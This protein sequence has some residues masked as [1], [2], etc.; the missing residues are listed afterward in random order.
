MTSNLDSN[1]RHFLRTVL[2]A[3]ATAGGAGAFLASPLGFDW[4]RREEQR[5]AQAAEALSDIAA[6]APRARFWIAANGRDVSCAACHETD[7]V[8][9][10]PRHIH[11][12]AYVGC[13][14]CAHRCVIGKGKRGRCRARMNVNGELRSLVYGHPISTHVDPV[15][16][17]P[18]YHFLPGAS[19]FSLATSGCP[20]HCRFCQNWTISQA[21]P[22]DYVEDYYGP[23]VIAGA[24]KRNRAP[25]I[26]YT[27]N[28]PTVFTEYL[29][30][31][32]EAGK[33]DGLRSV[34][35]SCGFMTEQPLAAMCDALDAIKIDLKGY[36]EEFYR[37]VCDAEM[38]PVLRSIKQVHRSGTHL[39]IVN[40][41]VPTLNDSEQMLT[42]L[43]KWVVGELGPD[44]PVH[45]TRF[46]PD[47]K[48]LNLP[49]TPVSTLERAREIA[50]REGMRYPFVGNVPGHEG[51][52]TYCPG[53]G[54]IVIRRQ[55]FFVVENHVEAGKC[56]F[57]GEVIAGVWE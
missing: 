55:S 17:K 30:D 52:H 10:E 46:H 1:R 14:L 45:Y 31:I 8:L 38:Q 51:N 26:A 39:E 20:L 11:T 23:E 54:E 7:E 35:I 37:N 33:R 9:P 16:K 32:A 44:V 42:E 43:A 22:E 47:Y 57:C 5:V 56:K 18:L 6:N 48:L 2:K 41:V 34:L 13:T 53:C 3:G 49:P 36:S 40:L 12:E 29:L 27:Y 15:E 25:I 24:A 19:A 21:G 50:L 28:E 4:L